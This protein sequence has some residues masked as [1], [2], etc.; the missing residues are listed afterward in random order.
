MNRHFLLSLVAIFFVTLL[1]APLHAA[2]YLKLDEI[3]GDVQADGHKDE[4]ELN[5]W[6]WGVMGGTKG[7]LECPQS[8]DVV[9]AF[10]RSSMKI[11]EYAALSKFIPQAIVTL[12][13]LTDKNQVIDYLVLDLSEVYFRDYEISSDSYSGLPTESFT[14]D[15]KEVLV[16]QMGA[17]SKPGQQP[18]EIHEFSLDLKVLGGCTLY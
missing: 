1:S 6:G 11:A 5:S 8:I 7:D 2:I 12:T 16:R 10:D 3:R 17:P 4:I 9:K 15:F 13:R 14:I 18:Q